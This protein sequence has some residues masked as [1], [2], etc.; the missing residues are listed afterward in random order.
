MVRP[1]QGNCV[2]SGWTTTAPSPLQ[3]LMTFC[4][5]DNLGHR[6]Y[7]KKK[8]DGGAEKDKERQRKQVWGREVGGEQWS[9]P[10]SL[11]SVN[12]FRFHVDLHV[13]D[14][15]WDVLPCTI[16]PIVN[17]TSCEQIDVLRWR[18]FKSK[19]V[20]GWASNGC[21]HGAQCTCMYMYDQTAESCEIRVTFYMDLANN[22]H[23]VN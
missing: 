14:Q 3:R 20:K 15:S 16:L 23:C 6:D 8:K 18:V 4:S 2:L 19:T 10:G 17:R 11:G 13:T 7:I 1:A 12:R 5:A 22:I 21:H 9:M